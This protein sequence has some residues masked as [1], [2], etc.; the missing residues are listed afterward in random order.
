MRAQPQQILSTVCIT[1]IIQ[2]IAIHIEHERARSDY[3]CECFINCTK[4]LSKYYNNLNIV[5]K[6]THN[7]KHFPA[8][9][10][11]EDVSQE[12]KSRKM[13]AI[14]F[15]PSQYQQNARQ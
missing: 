13:V 3:E 9:K 10:W 12:K 1:S 5:V 2:P 7:D 14:F 4:V 8:L 11:V 15:I 6:Y